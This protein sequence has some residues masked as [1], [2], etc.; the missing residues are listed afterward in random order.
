V[1]LGLNVLP[2]VHAMCCLPSSCHKCMLCFALSAC[3]VFPI[4]HIMPCFSMQC[5]WMSCISLHSVL[6]PCHECVRCSC[7]CFIMPL[8]AL[9]F[10]VPPYTAFDRTVWNALLYIINFLIIWWFLNI[11]KTKNKNPQKI[12]GSS[13]LTTW[14]M[15]VA[16]CP[17]SSPT[18]GAL[19]IAASLK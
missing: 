17:T 4:A 10:D 5:V 8:D 9:C 12:G 7:A 11:E 2:R 14:Q 16:W 15:T 19:V 13:M 3:H 18:G 1:A 6:M